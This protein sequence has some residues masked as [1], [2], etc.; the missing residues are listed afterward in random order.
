V[1]FEPLDLDTGAANTDPRYGVEVYFNGVL[2]QPQ[3]IIRPAQLGRKISTLGFTLASVNAAIGPGF[4]N[5]VTLRGTNYSSTGG[6]NWMG[7]DY[8]RL[9]PGVASPQRCCHGASGVMINGWPSGDGGGSNATFVAEN[10]IQ[11]PLPG[12]PASE[13]SDFSAD[14]DYYFAG[15]YTSVIPGNGTYVPVGLV[16]TNEEAAERGFSDA[17]NNLRYHFNLPSTLLSNDLLSVTFDA[18]SLDTAGSDPRYGVAVYFNQRP[19]PDADRHPRCAV[20]QAI[21]TPKFTLASVNAQVG[22]GFDNIVSLRGFATTP[23]VAAMDRL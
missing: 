22:P 8:V 7:I 11:N 16:S 23:R 15:L 1:S 19:G 14:N 20:G 18:L 10:G 17:G 2:V 12:D 9:D 4:D 13:E 6:G 3:L 21:T 5:I